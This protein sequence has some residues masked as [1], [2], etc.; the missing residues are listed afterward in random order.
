MQQVLSAETCEKLLAYINA[1]SEAS[2]AAV[3][4]GRVRF[5]DKFGGVNCRG[6]SSKYFKIPIVCPA[7]PRVLCESGERG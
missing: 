5:D 4:E 3:T 1:D 6:E 7:P 2:K